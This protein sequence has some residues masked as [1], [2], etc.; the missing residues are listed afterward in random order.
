MMDAEN[1]NCDT[2]TAAAA[3]RQAAWQIRLNARMVRRSFL[4]PQSNGARFQDALQM[5]LVEIDRLA[6][7]CDRGCRQLLT[8]T[9]PSQPATKLLAFAQSMSDQLSREQA[10]LMTILRLLRPAT[11]LSDEGRQGSEWQLSDA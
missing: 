11:G 10:E 7:S 5:K 6:R 8:L 1:L 3:L 4:N 9:P 2:A